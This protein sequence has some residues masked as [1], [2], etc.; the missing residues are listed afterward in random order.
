MWMNVDISFDGKIVVFDL[1]GDIYI[2]LM[3]GGIVM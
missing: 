3:L 2:M 1:F